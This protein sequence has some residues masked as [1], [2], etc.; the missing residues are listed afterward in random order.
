MCRF[1]G[2]VRIY[3]W[4]SRPSPASTRYSNYTLSYH[5]HQSLCHIH[6]PLP[7]PYRV[8][9]SRFSFLGSLLTCISCHLVIVARCCY[10]GRPQRRR[11]LHSSVRSPMSDNS[12]RLEARTCTNLTHGAM[13]GLGLRDRS[14]PVGRR[15]GRAGACLNYE[16]CWRIVQYM[17]ISR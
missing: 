16:R 9:S 11:N 2:L 4:W 1:N 13:T 8:R 6:V 5:A 17:P 7:Y 14:R 10:L 15:H 12:D 3:A